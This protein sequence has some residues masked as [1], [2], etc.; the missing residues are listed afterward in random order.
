[1]MILVVVESPAKC[2]KLEQILGEGY[3]VLATYGHMLDL[4][5]GV[6]LVCKTEVF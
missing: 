3:R 2:G 6:G 5:L 1:M 4:G